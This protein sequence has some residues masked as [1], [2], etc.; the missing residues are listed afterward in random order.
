VRA[1]A[2]LP[3]MVRN[4]VGEEKAAEVQA[5]LR[6]AGIASTNEK[7][8]NGL[9]RVKI[10]PYTKDEADKARAKVARLGL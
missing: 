2:F 7:S 5:K 6:A 4:I 3:H 10:G 8:A 1:S 9:V